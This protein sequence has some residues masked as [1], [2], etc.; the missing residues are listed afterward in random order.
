MDRNRWLV[1][2]AVFCMMIAI[3]TLLQKFYG[4]PVEAPEQIIA[5]GGTTGVT[6]PDEPTAAM[7]TSN[8]RGL[9][10]API[11]LSPPPRFFLAVATPED[12]GREIQKLAERGKAVK[13]DA[14]TASGTARPDG[15]EGG[16]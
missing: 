4:T 3:L 10:A 9:T 11:D 5:A 12:D 14:F 2:L 1:V 6:A 8:R 16:K 7:R 15:A 13:P